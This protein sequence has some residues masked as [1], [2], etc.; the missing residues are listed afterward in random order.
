MFRWRKTMA[1]AL[2]VLAAGCPL[3]TAAADEP[4][5]DSSLLQA[6][7]DIAPPGQVIVPPPGHYRAHLRIAR[8]VVLDGKGLVTLDGEGRDSVLVIETDGATVRNLR[9]TNSGT[10]HPEQDAGV[11][12]RGNHNLVEDNTIDNALFGFS[13]ERA[14]HNTIRRNVV[15]G[16]PIELGKRG[17]TLKLWYSHHNHI[18]DNEFRDGRDVVLWYST[19]NHY[20]GNTES[21]SRYGMH[22]MH[23]EYNLIEN[24]R[25]I[26]NSTGITMMY[27]VGDVIRNNSVVRAIGATGICLAMKESSDVVIEH[28]DFLYCSSGIAIDVAP[29]EPGSKNRIAGN[30]IAFND[31]GVTFLND[32]RDNVFTGNLFSGNIT[33]VAVYGG[34]SAKRNTWD[35]NRWEDYQG[36][37]R[38]GDGVGDTPHRL[39]GYAGRVWSDVPNTRFFKGSALLEA[40]DFLDRL[41]PFSEPVLL[42]EDPHPRLGSDKSF[43]AGSRS[44]PKS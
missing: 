44:R 1:K 27:D 20:I 7:I 26:D 9:L 33:E 3:T 30:R 5:L 39:F 32:W 36:F 40:L 10:N 38:N 35:G 23:A 24:N 42:L 2:L 18:E 15:T 16:K 14:D 13:L 8:P 37:D 41:A 11:Q 28:N 4:L 34:G 22:L 31:I 12:V 29:Y 21:G 17:D 25:F 19:N 43:E 6:L